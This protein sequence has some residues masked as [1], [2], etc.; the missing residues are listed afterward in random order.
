MLLFHSKLQVRGG[1]TH[2]CS[3]AVLGV[4]QKRPLRVQP[5]RAFGRLCGAATPAIPAT[6]VDDVLPSTAF[7]QFTAAVGFLLN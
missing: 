2:Y 6:Q 5:G 1:A 4:L 7:V 3:P